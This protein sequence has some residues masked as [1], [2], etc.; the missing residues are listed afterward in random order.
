[1]AGMKITKD[2]NFTRRLKETWGS[3]LEPELVSPVTAGAEELPQYEDTFPLTKQFKRTSGTG[4][5]SVN[6]GFD[7]KGGR[8]D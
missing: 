2:D 4:T 6:T 1:M 8:E 3:E 5:M 7:N